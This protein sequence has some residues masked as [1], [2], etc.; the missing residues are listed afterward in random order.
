MAQVMI[1]L[2]EEHEDIRNLLVVLERELA[3][4]DTAEQPDYDVLAAIADYFVGFLD[5]CH[6]SKEGLVYRKICER[7][8]EH[9]PIISELEAEHEGI[10]VSA[11]KFQEAVQN[12]LH[13][14]EISRS[15]FDEVTNHFVLRKRRHMRTEDEQVFPLANIILTPED[16]IE[17]D[18]HITREDDPVFGRECSQEFASLRDKI[19]QWE[20]EDEIGRT[21][22]NG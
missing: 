15:A 8:P 11:R 2:R 1:Q 20:S 6:H 4:F 17:I 10:A 18:D 14:A 9:A 21:T 22:G 16:W 3:L 7:A 12:I 13:D 5:R 19:M